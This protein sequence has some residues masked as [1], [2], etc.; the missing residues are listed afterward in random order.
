MMTAFT[1][2]S[3][4]V[5]QNATFHSTALSQYKLVTLGTSESESRMC[6]DFFFLGGGEGREKAHTKHTHSV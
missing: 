5:F 2:H 4:A 1:F 3:D 6:F